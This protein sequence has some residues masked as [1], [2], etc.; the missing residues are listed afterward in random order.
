MTSVSRKYIMFKNINETNPQTR[1]Y[2]YG[3]HKV[4]SRVGYNPEHLTQYKAA[5]RPLKPLGTILV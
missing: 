2:N 4:L 1:N 5:W 3:S